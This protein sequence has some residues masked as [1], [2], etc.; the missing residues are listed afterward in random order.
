M[1]TRTK[2]EEY[3]MESLS[4]T[5]LMETRAIKDDMIRPGVFDKNERSRKL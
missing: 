5:A 1:S 2:K 4:S 3:V